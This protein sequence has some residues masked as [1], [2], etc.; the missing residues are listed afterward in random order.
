MIAT[1]LLFRRAE[2]VDPSDW[3]ISITLRDFNNDMTK[4]KGESLRGR[5]AKDSDSE[6]IRLEGLKMLR[7]PRTE[8]KSYLNSNDNFFM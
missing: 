1:P 7:L 5:L 6:S 2:R 8:F 4:Y 3:L